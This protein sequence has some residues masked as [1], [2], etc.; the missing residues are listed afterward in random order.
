LGYDRLGKLAA[1]YL[2]DIV[3]LGLRSNPSL[4]PCNDPLASVVLC[5][6]G[7]DV[8]FAMVDGTVLLRDGTFASFSVDEVIVK[9][10]ATARRLRLAQ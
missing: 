9:V 8:T 7:R 6:S 3:G 4:T 10:E 2:A 5:G 1:G